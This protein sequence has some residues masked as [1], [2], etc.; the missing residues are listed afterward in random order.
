MNYRVETTREAQADRVTC[1][2]YIAQRS[3]AGALRW[4]DAFEQA[5]DS[6]RQNPNCGLAP[7]SQ[8][9]DDEIRQRLFKTPHGLQYRLL[10]VIRGDTIYILHV[11]G[12]G[13]NLLPTDSLRLPDDE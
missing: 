9:H 6:L 3:L 4:L 2:D 7:E 11:R 13:Q 8:D 1:Y 10:F 5:V 12:P